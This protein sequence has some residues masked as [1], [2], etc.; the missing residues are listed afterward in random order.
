MSAT[1]SNPVR[2]QAVIDQE[3]LR[4]LAIFHFVSAGMA[5]VWLLFVIGHYSIFHWVLSDPRMWEQGKEGPPPAV[6]ITMFRAMYVVFGTWALVAAVAN[7]LSGFYLKSRRH[8]TFSFVV[9]AFNCIHV[10]LGTILGAFTLIVLSRDSVAKSY[11]EAP[12][13]S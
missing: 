3:H 2:D 9:A 4:L 6:F 12:Q 10:P 11:A 1:A 13:R 5:F 8:R 7:L